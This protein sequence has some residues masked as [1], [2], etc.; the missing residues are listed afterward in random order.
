M[1]LSAE[2]GI[3]CLFLWYAECLAR[4]GRIAQARLVFEKML[5]YANPLG[6]YSGTDWALGRTTW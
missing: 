4:A 3:H 6:L 1:G 5:G 2:R